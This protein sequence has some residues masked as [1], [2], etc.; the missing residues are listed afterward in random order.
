MRS[1][2]LHQARVGTDRRIRT[3]V[4][5]M[6]HLIICCDIFAVGTNQLLEHISNGAEI[7][8]IDHRLAALRVEE[9]EDD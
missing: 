8:G 4:A 6:D 3:E 7:A 5:G 2:Q 1:Q 9:V